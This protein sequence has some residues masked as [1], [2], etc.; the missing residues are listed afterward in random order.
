MWRLDSCG[1]S[2]V[3]VSNFQ[4]RTMYKDHFANLIT[5]SF[6]VLTYTLPLCIKTKPVTVE[7]DATVYVRLLFAY[8]WHID[9]TYT[10]ASAPIVTDLVFMWR[11]LS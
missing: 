1:T 4:F 3:K 9:Q 5:F 2:D 6:S 7:E 8:I 11:L 10:V